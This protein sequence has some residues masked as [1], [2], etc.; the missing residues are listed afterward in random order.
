MAIESMPGGND[1]QRIMRELDLDKID[2]IAMEGFLAQAQNG[3][4]DMVLWAKFRTKME[5]D[6]LSW[7]EAVIKYEEAFVAQSQQAVEQPVPETGLTQPPPE[8]TA[9]AEALPGV[10]PQ[11]LLGA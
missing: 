5:K 1:A 10:P 3:A 7:S 8:A 6:G 11:A 2:N 4:I 9:P